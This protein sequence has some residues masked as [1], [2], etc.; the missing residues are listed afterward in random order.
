[1]LFRCPILHRRSTLD[2]LFGAS[3]LEEA[4]RILLHA[5]VAT[6][7]RFSTDSRLTEQSRE[8]YHTTSK[9]KVLLYG[10]E[11]SSVKALQALVILALDTV[12]SSNGP[13]GWNLLALITRYVVEHLNSQELLLVG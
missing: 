8:R 10:L 11:N 5:I 9:Q 1:M 3:T 4:D 2:T 13:P 6:T 7:L 12:G